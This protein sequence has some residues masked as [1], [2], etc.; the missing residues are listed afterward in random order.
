MKTRI[1]GNV[2]RFCRALALVLAGAS[3]AFAQAPEIVIGQ[4]AGYTGRTSSSVRE[5]MEG[6]QAWFEAV[7]K[8]G[9]I[10]G[11]KIYLTTLDDGYLPEL[12]A[13]NTKRLIDEEKAVAL[14]GYF[15]DAPVNV[16]LPIIKE[17]KIPLVGAV[18]GAEAQRS[19]PNLYFVRASYQMEVEK[20]VAQGTAQGLNKFA[21][22]YQ[23]DEFGKDVLAGLQKALG[24]RKLVLAGQGTYER[25]SIKV[26]ESVAKIAAAMPQSIVMACTLE[27]CAEFV[28]QIRK[29]GLSPRFN[30]LSVVDIASLFKELGDLSRGLEVSRVVPLPLM[31]SVPVVNEYTKA[32]KDFAPKAQTSFLGLEGFI[33]AKTLTEGLKRAGANPTRQNLTAALEG[34]RDVDLGGF[35]VNFA[36]A[37]RRGSDFADVTIIGPG[38]RIKY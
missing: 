20:I 26:D 7:N 37:N 25:N 30:H 13:E 3:G 29:R 1:L 14:F 18:S 4:S 38:G 17:K 11:R 24:A 12:V 5:F 35:I 27:A 8:K 22:F 9:G 2:R 36:G 34:M 23:N 28:R 15:G 32:L 10:A 31:Q 6:A 16:A 21:I 33:A 19:N